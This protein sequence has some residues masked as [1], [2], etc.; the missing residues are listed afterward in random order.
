MVL[1]V[2]EVECVANSGD[3]VNGVHGLV[4]FVVGCCVHHL[5]AF[6]AALIAFFISASESL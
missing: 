2:A 5:P 4:S 3:V 6:N 1:C